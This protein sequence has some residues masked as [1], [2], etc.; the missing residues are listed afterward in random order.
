LRTAMPD[1][2]ILKL[3]IIMCHDVHRKW[4]RKRLNDEILTSLDFDDYKTQR[5]QVKGLEH[6]A[7][8]LQSPPLGYVIKLPFRRCQEHSA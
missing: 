7:A 5:S 4:N 6:S 2:F 1:L 8:H 3:M